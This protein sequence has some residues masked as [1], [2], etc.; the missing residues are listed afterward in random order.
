MRL[1]FAPVI[2]P[3]IALCASPLAVAEW[4]VTDLLSLRS[5]VVE[6][7]ASFIQDRYSVLLSE[8]LRSRGRLHYRAPGFLLQEFDAPF[9]SRTVLDGE[10]LLT[11]RDG[12]E[13]SMPLRRSGRVGVYARALCGVLGGRIGDIGDHF[14]IDLSGTEERWTLRLT[15][16]DDL[17]SND[18]RN[19]HAASSQPYVEIRG[20]REKL[21]RIEVRESP[22]E[23]TV[24]EIREAR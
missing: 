3:V 11:W 23:R 7:H 1:G 21:R 6:T 10:T 2:V 13:V 15:L 16:R 18:G 5:E 8:P 24:M 19:G 9:A 14:R 22:A 17:S 4:T 20:R 12:E